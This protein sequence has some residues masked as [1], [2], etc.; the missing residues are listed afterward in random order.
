MEI[1][2]LQKW[3][4]N[5]T[6]LVH[7]MSFSGEAFEEVK[8]ISGKERY[9]FQLTLYWNEEEQ[10]KGEEGNKFVE[11]GIITQ[12]GTHCYTKGL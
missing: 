6:Y 10:K 2:V 12:D 9:N 8:E 4:T 3:N 7:V 1:L 11:L 5:N